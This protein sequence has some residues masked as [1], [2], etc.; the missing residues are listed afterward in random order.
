M[1]KTLVLVVLA[2]AL[3][4]AAL[5]KGSPNPKSGTHTNNGHHPKVMYVLKGDLGSYT[6]YDSSTNPATNGS[7]SIFVKH[8]NRHGKLLKDSTVA[9]DMQLTA[10]TK[11][12]YQHGLSTITD[13]DW[14]IVK[15]RAA[16]VSFKASDAATQVSN[17][18]TSGTVV[19]VIDKGTRKSSSDCPFTS[20]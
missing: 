14:G 2:L 12:K 16:K 15:I 3:P 19:Q 11:I 18:L 1:K 7:I 8:S 10:K 20:S 5:A 6:A 9:F 4:T 13:C 17:A